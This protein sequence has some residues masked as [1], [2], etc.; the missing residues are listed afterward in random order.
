MILLH[1][2]LLLLLVSCIHGDGIGVTTE[3]SGVL[4]ICNLCS[5]NNNN[6]VEHTIDTSTRNRVS[7][8]GLEQENDEL[9]KFSNS[10]CMN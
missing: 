4:S 8:V 10:Y 3:D 5:K 6:N 2:L 1:T 9:F 7:L